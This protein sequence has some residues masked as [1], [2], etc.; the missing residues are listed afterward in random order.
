MHLALKLSNWCLLRDKAVKD[1]RYRVLCPSLNT[2][3]KLAQFQPRIAALNRVPLQERQ[4]PQEARTEEVS[5]SIL[6]IFEGDPRRV[7]P[8]KFHYHFL[9]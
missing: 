9:Q 2:D 8:S 4:G 7:Q 5:F 1:V 6:L 3:S